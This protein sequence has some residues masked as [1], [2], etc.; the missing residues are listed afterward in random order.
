MFE[1]LDILWEMSNDENEI[2]L[3]FRLTLMT[4]MILLLCSVAFTLLASYNAGK[5]LTAVAEVVSSE[6][7]VI[8]PAQMTEGGFSPYSTT[9]RNSHCDSSKAQF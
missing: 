3:C 4:G 8:V 5:Q 7:L 2:F 6:G 9:D 1:A